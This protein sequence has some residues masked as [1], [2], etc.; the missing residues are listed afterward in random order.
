MGK[1]RA[2]HHLKQQD[3][4]VGKKGIDHPVVQS[5]DQ[6]LIKIT[7]PRSRLLPLR[8]DV[9]LTP[10][11]RIITTFILLLASVAVLAACTDEARTSYLDLQ[12]R[13]FIFNPRLATATYVVTLAVR[14][15]PP[16]GSKAIATFDNPAGGDPLKSEQLV[17]EGRTRIDFESVPL[18]CVKKGRTY[19]FT[20]TLFDADGTELQ[21]VRSEI[22]STLDQSILP[23]APLVIGPAYDKNPALDETTAKDALRQRE[24]C[25]A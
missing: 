5:A 13:V 4:A 1:V 11:M 21:T 17:R 20:V 22:T 10:V 16:P 9:D 8:C 3:V 18:R 25:P 14:K 6:N 15:A 2:R 19:H 12:G 23:P 7:Q 24:T